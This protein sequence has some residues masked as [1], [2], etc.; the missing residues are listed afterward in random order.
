M[1]YEPRLLLLV[2]ERVHPPGGQRNA[3]AILRSMIHHLA[4]PRSLFGR[5]R[6]EVGLFFS[7]Q[8]SF[9]PSAGVESPGSA[10]QRAQ[11]RQRKVE[12]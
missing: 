7:R 6:R 8:S 10:R 11:R 9:P 5:Q 3:R 4:A 1:T 2:P 12:A